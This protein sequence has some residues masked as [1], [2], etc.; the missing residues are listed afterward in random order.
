MRRWQT[1]PL[2]ILLALQL[3]FAVEQSQVLPEQF[4]GAHLVVS[5]DF[6]GPAMLGGCLGDLGNGKR[7][8]TFAFL[9]DRKP[10]ALLARGRFSRGRL[11]VALVSHDC[12]G[13]SIYLPQRQPYGVPL[14]RAAVAKPDAPLA[15]EPGTSPLLNADGTPDTSPPQVS[16]CSSP[17]SRKTNGSAVKATPNM[18]QSRSSASL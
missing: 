3:D 11:E 10:F 4:Q 7:F 16:R 15:F 12:G 18:R 14:E 1:A 6:D 17:I 8:E 13:T 5:T 2:H 9:H